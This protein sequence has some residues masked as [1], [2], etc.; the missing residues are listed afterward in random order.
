MMPGSRL[1]RFL[2]IGVAVI[3]ALGMVVAMSGP[4]IR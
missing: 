4:A 2:M 3:V 1:A